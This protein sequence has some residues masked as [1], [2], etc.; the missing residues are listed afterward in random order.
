M[1][2]DFDDRLLLYGTGMNDVHQKK[3][4]ERIVDKRF[5]PTFCYDNTAS[6]K[7]HYTSPEGLKGIILLI[8]CCLAQVHLLSREFH[9]QQIV[10]GTGSVK[11]IC[12]RTQVQ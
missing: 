9:R 8:P 12:R 2:I 11:S 5:L 10:F 1:G 7:Y 3:V 6:K 4:K